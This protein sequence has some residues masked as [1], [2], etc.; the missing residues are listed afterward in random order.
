MTFRLAVCGAALQL[1][2]L[3]L[4]S[5]GDL[6]AAAVEVIVL[7]LGTSISYLIACQS[8][9]AG[10]ERA[11]LWLI[12]LVAIAIRLTLAPALPSLSEDAFRYRWEG[13]L[14]AAGGNPYLARPSDPEWRRLRDETYPRVAARDFKAGYGPLWEL[15]EQGAYRA[16]AALTGDPWRQARLFKAPAALCDLAVLAALVWL[17]RLNGLPASRVVVYAWCP[18]PVV[19]FWHEGHNDAALLLFLLLALCLARSQRWLWALAALSGAVLIKW[20]PLALFPLFLFAPGGGRAR[21]W[22]GAAIGAAAAAALA[23]LYWGPVGENAAFMAGF[24]G[25]WRN[26]DSLFGA[27]LAL[28]GSPQRAQWMT[29]AALGAWV[30]LLV[31][32]RKRLP[33][34]RGTLL[35]IVGLLTV[36]ANVHPWYLTW[37]IPLLAIHPWTPLLAWVSLA[38]LFY[39]V[40]IGYATLGQW[41]GVTAWRW[42]VYAPVAALAAADGLRRLRRGFGTGRAAP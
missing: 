28:A 23:W 17:L 26:N 34:E 33:L 42:L 35:F 37:F 4:A 39:S 38:P 29:G 1:C 31:L 20:W 21:R 19:E 25:G 15:I 13:K 11:K 10:G 24:L 9:L 12:L 40:L 32:A 3:A 30:L 16:A 14:Q 8:V 27:L 2:F 6:A 22:A 36:S 41:D 5:Y 18:L 7:L